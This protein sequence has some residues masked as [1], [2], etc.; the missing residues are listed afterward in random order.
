MKIKISERVGRNES[1]SEQFVRLQP[2]QRNQISTMND[3]YIL[4]I[5]CHK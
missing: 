1:D 3:L 5:K 2:N 4:C